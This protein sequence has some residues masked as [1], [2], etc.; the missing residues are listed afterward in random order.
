LAKFVDTTC[1]FRGAGAVAAKQSRRHGVSPPN[2]APR[3][4]KLNYEVLWIG[5]VFIKFQNTSHPE[6]T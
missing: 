5:G 1:I 4:I 6:Q 3:P 2:K